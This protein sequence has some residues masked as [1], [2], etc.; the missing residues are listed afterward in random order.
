[1]KRR[2]TLVCKC[3]QHESV[4]EESERTQEPEP[5]DQAQAK[6]VDEQGGNLQ[7]ILKPVSPP[8]AQVADDEPERSWGSQSQRPTRLIY[9][10]P[11][12]SCS[13]WQ[14]KPTNTSR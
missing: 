5:S 1:M 7:D 13:H 8:M 14:A 4:I 9:G 12:S 2:V 10:Q 3:C 6:H 11:P